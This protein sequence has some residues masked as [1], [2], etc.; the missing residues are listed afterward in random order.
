[1]ISILC[2][3]NLIVAM[4]KPPALQKTEEKMKITQQELM[5]ESKE[6]TFY[7]SLLPPELKKLVTQ[8]AYNTLEEVIFAIRSEYLNDPEKR[9]KILNDGAFNEQLINELSKRFR[10][11]DSER[12]TTLAKEQVGLLLNTPASFILLKI[13]LGPDHALHN[14]NF[15]FPV[16]QYYIEKLN[17]NYKEA[18]AYAR[19]LFEN[20]DK[21]QGVITDSSGLIIKIMEYFVA[22]YGVAFK[23]DNVIPY[24][25]VLVDIGGVEAQNWIKRI[26]AIDTVYRGENRR[27]LRLLLVHRYSETEVARLGSDKEIMQA[28]RT[29]VCDSLAT[30]LLQALKNNDHERIQFLVLSIFTVQFLEE[31]FEECFTQ[32]LKGQLGNLLV[33]YIVSDDNAKPF[34]HRF[35]ST[36]M[37][38]A[39]WQQAI[40][41]PYLSAQKIGRLLLCFIF[42]FNRSDEG[43]YPDAPSI[44][45]QKKF[46]NQF[47][48][49][50]VQSPYADKENV[51]DLIHRHANYNQADDEGVTILMHVIRSGN[52]DVANALLRLPDININACDSNGHN[53]LSFAEL[54]PESDQKEVLISTLENMGAEEG[55]CTIQ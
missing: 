31:T 13:I 44:L 12:D 28:L 50:L 15:V 37:V 2:I 39:L 41:N 20:I 53:A 47:L 30:L 54:L 4:E 19:T 45:A 23:S 22:K 49:E 36:D 11:S 25:K 8:Y 18:L 40:H 38:T 27:F 3:S 33:D 21:Y 7:L 43:R 29:A 10:R 26:I 35:Y 24:I 32:H 48:F 14:E 34:K 1:M 6:K 42:Y 52:F 17:L 16:F 46:R 9:D 51:E 55:T 5:K